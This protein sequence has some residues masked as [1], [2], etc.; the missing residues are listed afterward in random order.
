LSGESEGPDETSVESG[1]ADT[2]AEVPD[3]PPQFVALEDAAFLEPGAEHAVIFDVVQ[4]SSGLTMVGGAG[5]GES[6]DAQT[7]VVWTIGDGQ[8]EMK[9]Q[10]DSGGRLLAIGVGRDDFVAVG[11]TP[12]AGGQDGLAVIGGTAAEF[13]PTESPSFAGSE[14]EAL[15]ASALDPTLS[16]EGFLVGGSRTTDGVAT[17][18]LWSVARPGKGIAPAWTAIPLSSTNPG[19]INDIAATS[20]LAVAVGTE[21]S[22]G[23][24]L[25]VILIRRGDDGWV[26]LIKPLPDTIFH[27][28][29]I[30]GERIVVVGEA[31]D[32]PVAIVSNETG[33]PPWLHRLPIRTQTGVARDVAVISDRIVAVGDVSDAESSTDRDGA[34]WELLP[35]DNPEAT[36]FG[37]DNWTTRASSDLQ[38]DTF[39]ELWAIAEFDGTTYV[40]GRT[41]VDDRRPAGAW[42]L[43]LDA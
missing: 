18:G 10:F 17:M 2:V 4:N 31:N 22:G 15:R 41:E 43:K 24:D 6:T 3:A 11:D 8:T 27:G 42:T 12:G 37:G 21:R 20:E 23:T 7:P 34:I 28:V 36:D 29:A 5:S 26:N 16:P 32:Q 38:T 19:T 35:D 30:A 33:E 25:G 9:R 14:P 40:F 13:T 39:T 1:D